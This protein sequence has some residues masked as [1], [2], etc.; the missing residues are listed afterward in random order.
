[1]EYAKTLKREGRTVL[2][3]RVGQRK[4]KKRNKKTQQPTFIY[5]P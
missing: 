3:L 2:E 1:M 4:R 5:L